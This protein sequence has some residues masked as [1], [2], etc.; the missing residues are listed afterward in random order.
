M[1]PLPSWIFRWPESADGHVDVGRIEL[2]GVVPEAI[3]YLRA[4]SESAKNWRDMPPCHLKYMGFVYRF[5][6]GANGLISA[7]TKVGTMEV[8]D[9]AF[10]NDWLV[11]EIPVFF[12]GCDPELEELSGFRLVGSW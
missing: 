5:D 6:T 8:P 4:A 2:V 9:E 3:G 11:S 10:E 12:P 1:K 7:I